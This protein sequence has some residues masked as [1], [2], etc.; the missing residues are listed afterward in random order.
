MNLLKEFCGFYPTKAKNENYHLNKDATLVEI[1]KIAALAV[2]AMEIHG[3]PEREI[4]TKSNGQYISPERLR[5]LK[6]TEGY[7]EL[8]SDEKLKRS[9][10]Y[11]TLLSNFIQ[12]D[13]HSRELGKFRRIYNYDTKKLSDELFSI[14]NR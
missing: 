2:R 3:C 8:S 4:D 12:W 10:E 6:S 1:R 14:A 5:E 13:Y 7:A 11:L 9:N